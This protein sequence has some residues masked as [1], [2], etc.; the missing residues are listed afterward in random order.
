MTRATPKTVEQLR[1]LASAVRRRCLDWVEDLSDEQLMGPMLATVNPLLWEIGHVAWFHEHWVLRHWLGRPSLLPRSDELYDSS[2]VAHAT[3]WKLNLPDRDRTLSYLADVR[4]QIDGAWE[5]DSFR[6]DPEVGTYFGS[7]GLFH[8]CMHTESFA[9]TR[10]RLG[11]AAPEM[12]STQSGSLLAG[13]ATSRELLGD[14]AFEGGEFPLGSSED[15]AFVF[16][17]EKWSHPVRVEPFRLSTRLVSQGEFLEFVEAEGYHQDR[18]WTEEGLRWKSH[19]GAE[20]PMYWTC[21]GG[22]WR[23]RQFDGLVPIELDHA[24]V[25]VNAFE[26]EAYCRWAGRRLPTEAEWELAASDWG[27]RRG[28]E[29]KKARPWGPEAPSL[30]HAAL[31]FR[32]IQSVAVGACAAG[33]SAR[34]V[35]QL[36]GNVWE[37]TATDFYPFPGFSADPYVDYSQPWFGDHRVVRGGSWASASCYVNSTYRNFYQPDRGDVFVGFRT[38]GI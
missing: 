33:D 24:M 38:C 26:A 27:D 34:G 20:A 8:E 36:F 14:V 17:N 11:V 9:Y 29:S 28:A 3:R 25:H 13:H 4:N 6:L 12:Y 32:A 19:I 2:R 10:Q 1:S 30:E 35:R 21:D 5:S 7:L 15:A 31:D 37:W 22:P 23:R 16:D 18:H